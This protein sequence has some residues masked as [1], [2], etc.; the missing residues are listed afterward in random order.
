MPFVFADSLWLTV[1]GF[2][3]RR[4]IKYFIVI[5]TSALLYL[6]GVIVISAGGILIAR[7]SIFFA[8]ASPLLLFF[9][10]YRGHLFIC[11]GIIH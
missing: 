11:R 6:A 9:T 3:R 5:F 1:L 7:I 4:S 10:D 2:L 8:H